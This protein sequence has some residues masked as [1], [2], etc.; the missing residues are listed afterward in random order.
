MPAC[1]RF[2]SQGIT[3]SSKQVSAKGSEAARVDDPADGNQSK[4]LNNDALLQIVFISNFIGIVC[5]RSLHYQFYSWY[6]HTLPFI[7][8]RTR[9][10]RWVVVGLLLAT[11]VRRHAFRP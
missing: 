7:L 8:L 5:A 6:F 10:P 1:Q 11:E 2:F 4:R 3:R 9:L